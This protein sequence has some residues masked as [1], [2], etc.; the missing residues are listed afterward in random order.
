MKQ[1]KLI[2]ATGFCLFSAAAFSQGAKTQLPDDIAPFF[3]GQK[4]SATTSM[5]SGTFTSEVTQNADGSAA[6]STG[7]RGPDA[8]EWSYEAGRHCVTWKYRYDN[9]CGT[10]TKEA[11]GSVKRTR[12]GTGVVTIWR[13]EQ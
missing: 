12:E 3:K 9:S 10:L 4:F 2:V 13:I 11:D 8:G 6:I 1:V 7:P 5:P